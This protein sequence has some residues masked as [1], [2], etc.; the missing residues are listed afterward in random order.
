MSIMKLNAKVSLL[1]GAI[2]L[3]GAVYMPQAAAVVHLTVPSTANIGASV[4]AGNFT[5]LFD[6]T[7]ASRA[8]G[9]GSSSSSA[10]IT[11]SRHYGGRFRRHHAKLLQA[12]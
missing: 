12:A 8:N 11:I 7:V 4:G 6:F 2:A 9:T 10:V 1:A 5:S 3:A